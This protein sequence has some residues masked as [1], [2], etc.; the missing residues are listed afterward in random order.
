MW[1][2]PVI[3]NLGMLQGAVCIIFKV[4]PFTYLV[5]GFRQAFIS[6]STI[7]TEHHGLY[8]ITFWVITILM[9]MWGN[10]VFKRSK[11]D[12]ADVL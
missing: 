12:F 5:E 11:K 2:T 8:T 1:F 6:S 4:F 10:S 7:I 9:F 3:W